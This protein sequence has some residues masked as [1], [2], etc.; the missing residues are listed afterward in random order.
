MVAR[1]RI[2]KRTDTRAADEDAITAPRAVPKPARN[3]SY[4]DSNEGFGG[5]GLSKGY[6]GS[7]GDGLGPSGPE[8]KPRQRGRDGT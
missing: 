3:R 2:K 1:S 5:E 8:Q 6:G 7:A 4:D